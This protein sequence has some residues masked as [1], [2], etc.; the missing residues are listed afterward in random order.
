MATHGDRDVLVALETALTSELVA[1]GR[2]REVIHR[3]QSAR[4]DADLDY[5]DRI[6]VRFLAEGELAE[7]IEAH[8]E[9]ICRETLAVEMTLGDDTMP[10]SKIDDYQLFLAIEKVDAEAN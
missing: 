7:A 8:R 3:L 2:A 10:S 5:A 1:E 4:K 9:G 6:R